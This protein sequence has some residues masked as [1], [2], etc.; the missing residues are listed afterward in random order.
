MFDSLQIN[1][2]YHEKYKYVVVRNNDI[3]YVLV[4]EYLRLMQILCN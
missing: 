4:T 2:R 1:F 3:N